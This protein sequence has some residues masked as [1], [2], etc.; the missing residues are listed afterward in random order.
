[1]RQSLYKYNAETCQYERVRVKGPDVMFY[2]SGVIVVSI[3]MLA[4][5]LVL[6]DFLFDSEKERLLRKQNSAFEKNHVLLTTQLS[7]IEST[8]SE[9]SAEDRKLHE[10]FFGAPMEHTPPPAAD[11][12]NKHLLLAD[13]AL[14]R[15]AVEKISA[16]SSVLLNGSS[17]TS[18]FF[19]N[20]LSLADHKNKIS[21]L[22]LLQPTRPWNP[23]NLISGFGMRINPFHKGL[24]EHPGVD[25]AMPRGSEVVAT[26][27]GVVVEIK[28]SNVQAGYGN[29]IDIDHGHG[30]VTRYAHLDSIRVKYHQKITKGAVI[31]TVGSSGGSIAPHLHYEI[32]RN[33]VTVDPVHYMIEGLSSDAHYR[34]KL[35]G[36]KQNQSLD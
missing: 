31:A 12:G 35:T 9:L 25:I 4:G 6:H 19:G 33:G 5:M 11:A 23:E 1:M 24:Y 16:R 27:A 18:S 2:I 32:I 36:E 28:R 20:K 29:Y 30:F 21:S 15:K 22:P 34:M 7:S 17:R 10:K 26:A 13:P 14:F 3:L 8:L